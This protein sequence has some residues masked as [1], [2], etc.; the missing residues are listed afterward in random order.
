VVRKPLTADTESFA[1]GVAKRQAILRGS[2]YLGSIMTRTGLGMIAYGSPRIPVKSSSAL[3]PKSTIGRSQRALIPSDKIP[4]PTR[5]NNWR[6][7]ERDV[8]SKSGTSRPSTRTRMRNPNMVRF[9]HGFTVAGV[10]V[11]LLGYAYVG[12]SMMFPEYD[13]VDDVKGRPQ[14]TVDETIA[15]GG[16]V[17]NAWNSLGPTQQFI[18]KTAVWALFS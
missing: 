7:Y 8:R 14:R 16:G 18:A 3:M 9:G 17:S 4:A 10:F 13:I 11:P 12:H 5:N 1:E 6:G 2:E 15:I